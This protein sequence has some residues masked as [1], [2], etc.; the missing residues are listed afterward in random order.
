[1]DRVLE[2]LRELLNRILEWW[3]R[4]TARQKTLIVS[5]IALIILAVV[6]IV[7][8]MTQPEYILL[9][10]CES[11]AEAAEI[12]D[13]LEEE[14]MTYTISEDGLVIRSLKEQ[15]SDA[16]LLLGANNIQAS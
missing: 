10:E 7:T 5:G 11:S 16:N 3:N 1:M 4:F 12:R 6:F 13:L 15:M 8:R 2:K 14:N 9:K